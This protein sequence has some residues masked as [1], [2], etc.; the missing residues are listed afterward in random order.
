LAT[1]HL[2]TE[3]A[4]AMSKDELGR[5]LADL[6]TSAA[7]QADVKAKGGDAQ[8]LAGIAR[9]HGYKVTRSDVEAHLRDRSAHLSEEQLD[10]VAGGAKSAPTYGI[11]GM[12]LA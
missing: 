7:L 10:G 9:R 3:G 11:G 6:A 1:V 8:V 4:D 12:Y 5:F 2:D